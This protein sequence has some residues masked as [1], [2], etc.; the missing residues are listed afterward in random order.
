M[1]CINV[2]VDAPGPNRLKPP[3][4]PGDD[5]SDIPSQCEGLKED[6][7]LPRALLKPPALPGD[8]IVGHPLAVRGA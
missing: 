8:D 5:F 3:A 6:A 7:V 2:L 1:G 4:P